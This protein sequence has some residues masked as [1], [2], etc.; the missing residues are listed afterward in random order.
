MHRLVLLFVFLA[1]A[2]NLRAWDDEW[3]SATEVGYVSRRVFRGVERTGNSAQAAFELKRSGFRGGLRLNEPFAGGEPGEA[4]LGAGYAFK[5]TDRLTLEATATQFLFSHVPAGATKR[6]AEAGLVATWMLREGFAP[7]LA[8]YHDFRQRAD[9]AEAALGYE[10]PLTKLG[11]YLELRLYAGW[12]RADDVRPDAAGPRIRDSYRYWG[13][14]TRLPYRVG[15]HTT[16]AVS[17]Q[18]AGSE[19]QTP[20]WSS[21]GRGSGT[22]GWVGLAVSFDF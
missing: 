9:I 5:P 18:V 7:S 11:T 4:D 13:V 10:V 1:V 16:L 20:I 8:Y 6:S 3:Q 14:E 15:E 21:I 17:A 22:R 19:N 12:S 2:A